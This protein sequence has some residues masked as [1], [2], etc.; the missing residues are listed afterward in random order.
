MLKKFVTV[1]KYLGVTTGVLI[2]VISCENDFRNVGVAIVDNNIFSTDKYTS[3]VISYSMN[4]ERNQSNALSYY[5]L[6]VQHD[7]VFGKLEASIVAQ[8]SLPETNP[9]FG[10]NAVI[11]SV[12]VDIPYLATLDGT[13]SNNS[14]KFVL[15]SIW[16]DGDKSI[17]LSVFELGTYLNTL[18]PDNP[19]QTKKY[20]S[21]DG[22][23]KTNPNT[24]FYSGAITP[25][26]IDTML[27]VNRYK[28]PNYPDLTTKEIYTTD[29]I[30][31]TDKKPSL[32]IPLNKDQIKTIFQDNT[33]ESDF[34]SNANFQHF[35]RGLY[36]EPL[37]TS[38]GNAS[39]MTLKMSDAS[40][41]IYF[42]NDVET[43]EGEDE[44]LNG[45]D[46]TGETFTVRTPESFLF[47]LGGVK[48][49]LYN[50]DDSD[51]IV[52]LDY[53]NNQNITEG[54]ELVYVQGAAGTD[55]VIKLFGEADANGNDIPD[56][57]ELLRTKNWLIN[58]AI[59][60]LYINPDNATNWTPERLYLYNIGDVD[61][62]DDGEV[63]NTQLLDAMPQSLGTLGGALE[64]NAADVPE[65]YVFRI[66]DFISEIVKPDSEFTLLNLGVKVFNEN[67][68]PNQQIST[69]TIVEK[70]NTNPKGISLIGNLPIS[71]ENRIKLE[72]FYSEKN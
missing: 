3:E 67:D 61:L 32:K 72:I 40:M 54:E 48:T 24:P 60:T 66:T 13:H 64:K 57:L 21:N 29:T 2:G 6:G 41:I 68:I 53:I 49:N 17:Q 1:L 27:L 31:K 8:L 35:F 14:P 20:Y 12:I 63:D 18:D 44:D 7:D 5:L 33:S 39:L 62:D 65:K 45:N 28:Y 37:E 55:A 19:T 70:I 46:I 52:T 47:P 9:D 58:D 26:E 69:D 56:E 15:D 36:F 16:T 11:D 43:V 25:S 23:I 42:S 51:A 22:F 30:K 38:N 59:L 10:I 4:I 50:R 71:E 34:A